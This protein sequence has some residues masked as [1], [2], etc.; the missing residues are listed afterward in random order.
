MSSILRRQSLIVILCTIS[1]LA[2]YFVVPPAAAA[3]DVTIT[4]GTVPAAAEGAVVT[5]PITANEVG[6][7]VSFGFTIDYDRSKLEFVDWD[8]TDTILESV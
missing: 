7:I 1:L 8:K 3:D 2:C 4:V 5:I 6:D